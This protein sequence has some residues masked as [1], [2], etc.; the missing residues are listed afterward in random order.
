MKKIKKYIIMILAII[1]L[2]SCDLINN[3]SSDTYT[4]TFLNY[5]NSLLSISSG[6]KAGNPAIYDGPT[7]T[8]PDTDEYSY[9]FVGWDKDIKAVYSD[10]SVFANYESIKK[11]ENDNMHTVDGKELKKVKTTISQ[12]KVN[13]NNDIVSY[14]DDNYYYFVFDLGVYHNIPVDTAYWKYNYSGSGIFSDSITAASTTANKIQLSSSHALQETTNFESTKNLNVAL[15]V[16]KEPP[17]KTGG[18]SAS[19]NVEAGYSRTTGESNSESWTNTY[20]EVA[21]YS[22]SESRTTTITLQPG[23][24]IGNYYYYL[25]IDVQVYGT[26]VKSIET[27]EFFVTTNTSVIGRGFNFTCLGENVL[28]FDCD[29]KL[30]FDYF[31]IIERFDLLNAVP[32]NYYGV[33]IEDDGRIHISDSPD[34]LYKALSSATKDDIIVLDTEIDCQDFPWPAIE[35]FQGTLLGNGNKIKNIKYEITNTNANN[36]YYGLF[37]KVSGKISNVIF[38]N[39]YI[40]IWNYH[41]R[42]EFLYVGGICAILEGEVSYVTISGNSHIY[43]YNDDNENGKMHSYVGGICGQMNYGN[44]SH[45]TI[46]NT[47]VHG[48]SHVD[49][50][51]DDTG[52]CWS[53]TGGFV[54]YQNGGLI[55][56]CTRKNNTTITSET[57]SAGKKSAYHCIVGGIVGYQ[58]SG[59]VDKSCISSGTGLNTSIDVFENIWGNSLTAESSEEKKGD[60]IGNK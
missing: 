33:E 37:K 31:D 18:W 26:I 43:G 58:N 12:D 57:V 6:I 20:N 15:H 35:N 17:S 10:M 39:I 19:L 28:E 5:D 46:E 36:I 54:G 51:K 21:E 29:D 16:G 13:D 34:A 24:K 30:N 23:D 42:A 3:M 50:E 45:C 9:I 59:T 40:H 38:E 7:P 41:T 1:T 55:D 27:G 52:D 44:I 48:K 49:T 32:S 8:R 11:D 4:V 53:Y 56:N 2:C 22:C 25:T 14:R 47:T 60:I